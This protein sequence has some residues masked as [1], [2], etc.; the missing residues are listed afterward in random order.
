MLVSFDFDS[1]LTRPVKESAAWMES[2]FWESSTEPRPEAVQRAKELAAEG[3]DVVVVT[4]RSKTNADE[5]FDF[6]NK[7]RL[8]V[9]RVKFTD[10]D[11]KAETLSDLG[12]DVHFDDAFCELEALQG[13]E[14]TGRLVPHPHDLDENPDRVAEFRKADFV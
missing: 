13:T 8:N 9:E 7:H 6:L 2:S 12:V 3:H 11:L 14:T 5:V 1:T 10:G 4:S